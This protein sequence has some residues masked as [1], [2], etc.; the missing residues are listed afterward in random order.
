MA[1]STAPNDRSAAI[2]VTVG[3]ITAAFSARASHSA[4]SSF[5]VTRPMLAASGFGRASLTP[6]CF[7]AAR[8]V[9]FY[10]MPFATARTGLCLAI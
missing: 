3:F 4:P 2:S 1:A 10:G 8:S 6:S 5:F 9:M 7:A